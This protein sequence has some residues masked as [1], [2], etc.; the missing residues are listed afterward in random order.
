MSE[1][2]G[3]LQLCNINQTKLQYSTLP[4]TTRGDLSTHLYSQ[5]CTVHFQ[6]SYYEGSGP[7]SCLALSRHPACTT[8][9]LLQM[10]FAFCAGK[11]G[12][13]CELVFNEHRCICMYTFFFS[14]SSYEIAGPQNCPQYRPAVSKLVHK[15]HYQIIS[16]LCKLYEA[17]W[18]AFYIQTSRF[19]AM[20]TKL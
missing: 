13:A 9:W 16:I 2:K 6:E 14:T 8:C 7:V 11:H 4:H 1:W 10:E 19:Q 5:V 15:P 3:K 18:N 20:I 17:E 12:L